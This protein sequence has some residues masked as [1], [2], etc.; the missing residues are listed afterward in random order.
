MTSTPRPLIAR[1]QQLLL[2]H[3]Q[4]VAQG[5]A[6]RCMIAPDAAHATGML[7]DIG[8]ASKAWQDY[9]YA[10]GRDSRLK[11]P[12][13]SMAGAILINQKFHGIG[14]LLAHAIAGH[15]GGLPDSVQL[16]ERLKLVL[17]QDTAHLVN[18]QIGQNFKPL[19]LP[20][21]AIGTDHPIADLAMWT[22]MVTSSLVDADWNDSAGWPNS[23]TKNISHW[24]RLCE[25]IDD[26]VKTLNPELP[27]DPHASVQSPSAQSMIQQSVTEARRALY[28]DA[29]NGVLKPGWY[30][31][32]APTGAGK[33]LAA[34][35]LAAQ[36][37]VN[38]GFRRFICAIPYTSI[39]QQTASIYRE[40]VGQAGLSLL[41]H[42]SNADE[43]VDRMAENWD[44]DVVVTTNV[45]L[46]ESLYSNKPARLR[47]LHNIAGSVIVL[48]EPQ[49]VPIRLL[50]PII[51]A[52][53]QLAK[54]Y[55]CAIVMTTAT[56][57]EWSIE[58]TDIT[59]SK[60]TISQRTQ[61]RVWEGVTSDQKIVETLQ[62]SPQAMAIVNTR[63]VARRLWR[64]M[65][66]T[67]HLS[68]WMCPAH[69]M[70]VLNTIRA[71]L[72]SGEKVHLVATQLVE[73]GVDISFPLVLRAWAG[74][75]SI[76][77]ANGRCNRHGTDSKLGEMIV[78]DP[79]GQPAQGELAEQIAVAK[80]VYGLGRWPSLIDP[81]AVKLYDS[82]IRSRAGPEGQDRPDIMGMHGVTNTNK[83][84]VSIRF[85]EIATKMQMIDNMD[86][87]VLVPYRQ[88]KDWVERLRQGY[89]PNRDEIREITRYMASVGNRE[90][91]SLVRSGVI[92]DGELPYL[93]EAA[94]DEG[95]MVMDAVI[96]AE[97]LVI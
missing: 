38:A 14:Y 75:G 9:I 43:R 92:V 89:A 32:S 53:D 85:A 64:Q 56:P 50:T 11:S 22:R 79:D 66:D 65:S 35:R 13:H 94:Y 31:V 27:D 5:A 84:S 74:L 39:T 61:V 36:S 97:A 80:E 1:P 33:T 71:K 8:K 87:S 70:D 60:C 20:Y 34:L 73:A 63:A 46:L 26:H 86:T 12:G 62:A 29:K 54:V 2:G 48:D 95:G 25:I 78:F 37:C 55:G 81:D 17:H 88:G 91:E 3:L 24:S 68:T 77:Q 40:I 30:Q 83:A 15:H 57:P 82:L 42:H 10:G 4:R 51:T 19:E 58:A 52:L 44:S 49:S 18:D 23:P 59:P 69:R 96:A 93:G 72:R 28:D 21:N 67:F 16:D 76:T 90:Y 7:H 6:D 41:E 47:K 45:Q